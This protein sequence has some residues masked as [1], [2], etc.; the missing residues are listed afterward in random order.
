MSAKPTHRW[1]LLLVALTLAACSGSDRPD[2]ATWLP[3]WDAVVA[4][5][6]PEAGL[7]NPPNKTRCQE[8]LAALRTENEDL[9]PAPSVTVDDLVREWIEVAQ[10][11][12]FDCPPAGDEINSFNEAYEELTRIQE[13]VDTALTSQG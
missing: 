11:A 3:K 2:I 13:S 4:V 9:L 8:T 12:F 7:G 6:P 10:A 1:A 5:V